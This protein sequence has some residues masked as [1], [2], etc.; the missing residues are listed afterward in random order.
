MLAELGRGT[1]TYFPSNFNGTG[2]PS[3]IN[4][5]VPLMVFSPTPPA[6]IEIIA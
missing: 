4:E 2:F 6:V 1:T 3:S 5:N